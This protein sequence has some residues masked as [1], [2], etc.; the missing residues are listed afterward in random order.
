M[1]ATG[2]AVRRVRV[3]D[4][5]LRLFHWSLVGLLAT[6]WIS[7][8]LGGN[9]MQVHQWSGMS[10]LALL[11]FRLAWGVVGGTHARFASFVRSPAAALR[12]ARAL[13]RGDAP[14]YPGHNPLGAWMVLALLASLVLQAG[15]G[16][17]ANDDIMIEGPLAAR[18]SKET[19]DLLTQVHEINFNVLLGL[20]GVH[21]LAALYYLLVKRDNLITPMVT[22]NKQVD[23]PAAAAGRGGALWLAALLL[24]CSAAA[25]WLLL[26]PG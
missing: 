4:L 13:L 12:Y 24:A 11:L 25:V 7:A 15:T 2:R 10:V 26:R 21:V 16:L 17:F 9:A 22:G 19:S 14:R 3:W 18:V 23:D 6:S 5:P 1:N 8:E 20:V